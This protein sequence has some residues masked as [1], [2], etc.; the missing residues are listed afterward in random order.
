MREKAELLKSLK[1]N[2]I[3][4]IKK[5]LSNDK[6]NSTLIYH[7]LIASNQLQFI[8]IK[9]IN[10][11]IQDKKFN[12]AHHSNLFIT[13]AVQYGLIDIV[14]IL[15]NDIRVNASETIMY[16]IAHNQN[17]KMVKLLLNN[18]TSIPA[19]CENW[20]IKK[21]IDEDKDDVTELLF[22]NNNVRDL[23]KI[24]DFNIYEKLYNHYFKNKILNF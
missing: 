9:C 3:R 18:K 13:H 16:A 7:S 23:L 24:H 12:P 4:E 15:L 14:E 21:S 22:K 2:K 6:I 5:H 19:I 1:N 17:I 10:L 8:N 11:L 20:C